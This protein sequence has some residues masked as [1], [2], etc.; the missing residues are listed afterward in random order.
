M[1]AAYGLADSLD[2]NSDTRQTVSVSPLFTYMPAR[3]WQTSLGY[4]FRY[5]DDDG[6]AHSHKVFFNVSRS[7]TPLP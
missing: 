5:S 3:N 1:S 2:G 7:F 4:L 6:S